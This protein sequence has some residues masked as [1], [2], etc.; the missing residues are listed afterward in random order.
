MAGNSENPQ[1]NSPKPSRRRVR[2]GNPWDGE[3]KIKLKKAATVDRL[4]MLFAG[5]LCI[6]ALGSAF[7]DTARFDTPVLVF[8]KDM[9]LVLIG[10]LIH[11]R[12][13]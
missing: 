4:T 5:V 3:L 8:I 1:S 7:T 10:W 11:D 12:G 9:T 13:T 2:V 6:A